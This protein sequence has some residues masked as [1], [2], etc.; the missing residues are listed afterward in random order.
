MNRRIRKALRR[1]HFPVP[2]DW[3]P[4]PLDEKLWLE[5]LG[6]LT[7]EEQRQLDRFGWTARDADQIEILDAEEAERRFP[8]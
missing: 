7:P 1:V 2:D 6:A 3:V 4:N 8:D 5:D